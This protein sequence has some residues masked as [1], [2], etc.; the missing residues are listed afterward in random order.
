M[1]PLQKRSDGIFE[2]PSGSF[3]IIPR[4]ATG[5]LG[6]DGEISFF[7]FKPA[8]F[9]DAIE[10]RWPTSDP[11][12]II[13]QDTAVAMLQRNYALNLTDELFDR[14]MM[15]VEKFE[16]AQKSAKKDPEPPKTPEPAKAPDFPPPPGAADAGP[17]L[18]QAAASGDTP[19]PP[20]GFVPAGKK[21]K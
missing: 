15:E 14:Y 8:V 21:G 18:A 5:K 4:Y 11:F 20:P 10:V 7:R 3:A 12:V 19:P 9:A 17:A 6:R 2:T 16:A 1:E 13:E